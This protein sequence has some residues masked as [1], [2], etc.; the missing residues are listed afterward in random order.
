MKVHWGYRHPYIYTVLIWLG[1]IL[2]WIFFGVC[3]VFYFLLLPL[4]Y[5][6]KP[7]IYIADKLEGF[8]E[9]LRLTKNLWANVRKLAAQEKKND[10]C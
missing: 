5:A 2:Y 6:A 7:F 4:A 9:P 3:H 1:T 8:D 10:H